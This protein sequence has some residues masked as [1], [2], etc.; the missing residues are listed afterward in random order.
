MIGLEVGILYR[1]FRATIFLNGK[2]RNGTLEVI[3]RD[4]KEISG[5]TKRADTGIND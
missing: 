5:K 2:E 1:A 4:I 3:A